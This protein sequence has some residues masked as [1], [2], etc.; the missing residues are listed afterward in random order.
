MATALALFNGPHPVECAFLWIWTNLPLSYC[1]VSNWIFAMR[2]QSMSFIRSW[3]QV[4]AG[5]NLRREE[6]K[7]RRNN[8]WEKCAKESLHNLPETLL[9]T[10]PVLTVFIGLILG[11]KKIKD[12]RTPI[13]L[14]LSYWD[15]ADSGTLGTHWGVGP[16][17]VP[18]LHPLPLTC[19]RGIRGNKKWRL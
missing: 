18:Q 12:R 7:D 3:S 17:R 1:C 8:Q 5:L 4:L 11:A 9:N 13:S 15:P 10:W 6:L 2:H 14:G 19:S 16:A